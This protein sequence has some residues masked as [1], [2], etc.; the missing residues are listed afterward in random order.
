MDNQHC[1]TL[2]FQ[3]M[4]QT[5]NRL[6]GSSVNARK[7]LIHKVELCILGKC[8]GKEHPLLLST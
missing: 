8:S 2:F 7:R 1:F 6:L 5:D 3:I 4:Q